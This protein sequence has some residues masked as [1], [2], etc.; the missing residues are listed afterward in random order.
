MKKNYILVMSILLFVSG[1]CSAVTPVFNIDDFRDTAWVVYGKN[2][3]SASIVGNMS[4]EGIGYVYFDDDGTFS[5]TDT[6]D[7]TVYGSYGVDSKG[8]L[9]VD[10]GVDDIQAFYDEYLG[11]YSDYFTVTVT[12]ASSSCKVTYSGGMVSLKITISASAR[13][14]VYYEDDDGN[15]KEYHGKMSFTINMSGDH[16]VAGGEPKWA[17]KWNINAN[18]SLKAKKIKVNMPMPVKLSL[19]DAGSG[20]G[21][22]E[23]KFVDTDKVIFSSAREYY[24]CRQKNKII[25]GTDEESDEMDSIISNLIT[26]NS[27][28]YFDD[29]VIYSRS[30]TATIKNDSAISL[31]ITVKFFMDAY[32]E[33]TEEYVFISKG[34]LT[35]TGSGVPAP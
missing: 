14:D 2:N 29:V 13:I 18:A 28:V 32:D 16:P 30:V 4:A 20:L 27:S 35:L 11:D 24:F 31:N 9:F 19:G 23:Y 15:P 21:L 10:V 5:I 1:F 17:S 34:T 33:D 6:A 12:K 25:L 7:S 26:A 22:N 3:A 8:K